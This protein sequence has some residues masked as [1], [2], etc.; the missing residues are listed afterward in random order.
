MK[1]RVREK[2]LVVVLFIMVLVVFSFA[3]RDSEKLQ[4]LRQPT[5]AYQPAFKKSMTSHNEL[6]GSKV[7]PSFNGQ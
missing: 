3:Q 6:P 4:H 5:Q 2:Y 1:Q 7:S